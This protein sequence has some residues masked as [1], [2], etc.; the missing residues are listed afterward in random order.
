MNR[1]QLNALIDVLLTL[2]SLH[3]D[4]AQAL[5][6]LRHADGVDFTRVAETVSAV[7]SQLAPERIGGK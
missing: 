2:T 6:R 1:I 4:V 7:C 3:P 5:R